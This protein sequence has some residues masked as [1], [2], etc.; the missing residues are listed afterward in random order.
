MVEAR[1]QAA[2]TQSPFRFLY[3]SGSSAERDQAKKPLVLPAYMLMRGETENRVLAFAAEQQPAGSVEACVAKP[4][5]I[6]SSASAG[7]A[8]M[9]TVLG[10]MS[11]VSVPSVSVEELAAAMLQQVRDGFEKEPLLNEDLQRIGRGV[12]AQMA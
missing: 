11:V 12:L 2:G 8:V 9:G 10:W 3:M 1:Q 4:G 6:T 5:M 7:Q